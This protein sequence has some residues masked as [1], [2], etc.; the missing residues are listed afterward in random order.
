MVTA[1]EAHAYRVH[2][3]ICLLQADSNSCQTSQ[4]AATADTAKQQNVHNA[5][6]GDRNQYYACC[7]GQIHSSLDATAT[8]KP[9]PGC[10]TQNLRY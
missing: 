2:S 7:K 6:R 4:L 5:T 8:C 3:A 9:H 10:E 1:T